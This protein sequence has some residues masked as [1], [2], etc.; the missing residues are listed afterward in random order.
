MQ[1]LLQ[2]IHHFQDNIFS[3][4]RELFERLAEGQHP[5]ALFIT[6]SDSRISPN[7]ITQ[8]EPGEPLELKGWDGRTLATVRTGGQSPIQDKIWWKSWGLPEPKP[9]DRPFQEGQ[10]VA[11]E[12]S[13]WFDYAAGDATHSYPPTRVQSIT[14]QF[15]YLRPDT[16]VIFDRVAAAADNLETRWLLHSLYQ[17][18]FDGQ[19]TSDASL[20]SAQQLSLAADGRSTIPNPQPGG[21]FLHHGGSLLTLD[22]Q[23]S[24]M[25]GQ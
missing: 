21:R 6:C 12:T 20:P 10:I 7:L 14:R 15:V 13:P 2:G 23:G 5:D 22:D 1:K 17:P 4:Q 9:G 25:S 24:D 3:S 19:T 8:T 16:F 18:Q 11:Y